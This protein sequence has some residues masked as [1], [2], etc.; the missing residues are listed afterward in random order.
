MPVDRHAQYAEGRPGVVAAREKSST[1]ATP[2]RRDKV[3][4]SSALQDPMLKDYV[5]HLWPLWHL[6]RLTPNYVLRVC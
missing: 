5:G 4:E 1:P 2:S 6:Q 3:R